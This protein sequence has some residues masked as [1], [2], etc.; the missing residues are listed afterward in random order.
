MKANTDRVVVDA[1]IILRY[2]LQ[3]DPKQ[4]PKADRMMEMIQD[5]QVSAV[6]DPVTLAEV[7]WV[8]SAHY[9]IS[10]DKI[11]AGLA[12]LIK[13]PCFELT[14]KNR[15]LLALEFFAAS[16]VHYGDACACADA[17]ELSGG[18][19]LSFDRKLAGLPGIQRL[20]TVG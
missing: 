11:V 16:A 6:C 19:I 1:N 4:S 5:E 14:E 10:R 3:D 7:V 20:E 13:A 18:R 12:P 2:L 15:Y 9:G 8:L 17:L